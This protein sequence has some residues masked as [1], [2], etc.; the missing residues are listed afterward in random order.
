MIIFLLTVTVL[1]KVL[2][3]QPT[4]TI[5]EYYEIGQV[6]NMVNV[7]PGSID[8]GAP[9][10]N[11]VWDFSA[12]GANGGNSITTVAAN[13][14]GTFST[15][16][17]M[18]TRPNGDIEYM[19]ENSTDSYVNGI[20]DHGTHNTTSYNYFNVAKRPFTYL[21]YYLD[22]Y[23]IVATTPVTTG[24]G[25]MIITSNAWGTLKLPTGTY[26]NV[27]LI[28]KLR[29]ETDTISSATVSFTDITYQWFDT[30]HNAPLLEVDSMIHISGNTYR[31]MYLASPVAVPKAT[32]PQL[33]YTGY[34]TSNQLQLT[35][36]FDNGAA[37]H[38]T[39]YSI[40][41]TKIYTGE[42]TAGGNTQRIDLGRDVNPGIYI[43]S[44][45]QR[46]DPANNQVIKVIKQ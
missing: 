20:T 12:V 22:T 8:I 14:T 30:A 45:M 34:M 9:G 19:S 16:N 32:A 3:A 10:A 7:N 4:I 46:N 35:G 28:K 31:A 38:V 1:P 44:L 39:V 18:I 6:I 41:G 36:T 17:L 2:S 27:L 40:I 29:Q 25:S 24:N 43:V 37:Y 26:P 15:S 5:N 33:I 11:V 42:F 13:T 21:G 23:K